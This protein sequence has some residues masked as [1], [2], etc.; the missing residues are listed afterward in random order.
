[1][2]TYAYTFL[3]SYLGCMVALLTHDIM[4]KVSE[5]KKEPQKESHRVVYKRETPKNIGRFAD[6]LGE[7]EAYKDEKTHLYKTYVPKRV[8]RRGGDMNE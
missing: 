5:P 6:P 4:L 3:L 8:N 1:M 2:N 7:Y